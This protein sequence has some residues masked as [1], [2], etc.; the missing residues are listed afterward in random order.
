M[1]CSPGSLL[2]K[3]SG[4]PSPTALLF[5]GPQPGVLTLVGHLPGHLEEHCILQVEFILPIVQSWQ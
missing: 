4:T 5:R 1:P 2:L 3:S